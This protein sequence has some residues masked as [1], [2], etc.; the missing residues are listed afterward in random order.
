M[1]FRITSIEQIWQ[2][3]YSLEGEMRDMESYL[4]WSA[5]FR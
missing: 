1:G 2:S 3:I 4:R 5:R